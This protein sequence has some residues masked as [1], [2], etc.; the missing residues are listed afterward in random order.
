MKTTKFIIKILICVLS[1]TFYYSQ[2]K[3][4]THIK[5]YTNN[6]LGSEESESKGLKEYI[7]DLYINTSIL[8]YSRKP[9][10]KSGNYMVVLIDK[11][12]ESSI[13]NTS[14][15]KNISIKDVDYIRYD[16]TIATKALYG[17]FSRTLGMV[18]I[19]LK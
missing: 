16:N 19:K 17:D 7:E 2:E 3:K 14:I 1:I 10:I 12:N 18:H 15:L 6:I 5:N 8:Y 9:I 4:I 11:N 13:E